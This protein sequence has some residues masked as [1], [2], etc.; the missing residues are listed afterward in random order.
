M[1]KNLKHIMVLYNY[2]RIMIEILFF[3][4]FDFKLFSL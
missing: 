1:T 3:Q 4:N 2:G